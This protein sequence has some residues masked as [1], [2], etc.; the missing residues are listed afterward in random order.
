MCIFQV[1][2]EKIADERAE[3]IAV[4]FEI[5]AGAN[6]NGAIDFFKREVPKIADLKFH[7]GYNIFY[8]KEDA[9]VCRAIIVKGFSDLPYT[10]YSV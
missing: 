7:R 9:K 6:I 3:I 8:P 2:Q 1:Y 4:R 5:P 10:D